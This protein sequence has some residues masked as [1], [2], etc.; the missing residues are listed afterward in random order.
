MSTDYEEFYK[1]N[2]HGL[3]KP[4]KEFVS[5]FAEYKKIAARVLDLGCGQGRDAVFIARQGHSVVGVDIAETGIKQLL[6][7]AKK[8]G[9]GIEGV[10]ADVKDY[11][12]DSN[13][14]VVVIDRT[15]HMLSEESDRL[16]VLENLFSFIN[17]EG[18]IL[19][20]DEKKNLPAMEDCLVK[21]GLTVTL[22]HRGFLF[23]QK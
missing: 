5:F 14:D 19:I 15:L 12:P 7:D 8:E 10:V 17:K 1:E 23:V 20:A 13:F 3:G 6:K 18:Y 11:V 2:P 16:A 21:N 4:F 22:S 9:L